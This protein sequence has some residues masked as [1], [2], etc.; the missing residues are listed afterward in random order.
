MLS[1]SENT[2]CQQHDHAVAPLRDAN[3]GSELV[4]CGRRQGGLTRRIRCLLSAGILFAWVLSATGIAN[5]TVFV[6]TNGGQIEGQLLNP[7]QKPRQTYIVR[8]RA[9]GTVTLEQGQVDRVLTISEDLKWY[10]ESLPKVPPTVEGHWTMAEQCKDRGLRTQGEFHLQEIVK[11]DPAHEQAHYALGHS[12]IDGRWVDSDQWMRSRGYVRY[13][14]AWRIAQ[15]VALE[16]GNTKSSNLEKDWRNKVKTWRTMIVKRRGKEQEALDAIKEI[17]DP[18]AATALVGILDDEAAPRQLRML[19]IEVLGRLRTSVGTKSFIL[20]ALEDPDAHIRDACLDQLC[21]FQTASA[22]N[23]FMQLLKSRDNRKVNR[24]A[25]CLAA[26][27]D[28]EAALAL[29]EALTTK[30]KFKVQTGS[31]PGQYNL[32]FGGGAGS[33]GNTFGAGGRPKIF[34]RELTNEGVLNALV[35]IFPGVNFGYDTNAWKRWYTEQHR[36]SVTSLRRDN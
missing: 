17:E 35:A 6:L 3:P 23:A 36:S 26:L 19:C 21:E 22:V 18:V 24:A 33:S 25:V 27:R 12:K 5:A 11:L 16:Q 2:G 20:R 4:D 7:D 28:P 34:E 10:R 30:H 13:R 31:S 32:G 1:N 15:D 14:G 8:T 29:V 9:G